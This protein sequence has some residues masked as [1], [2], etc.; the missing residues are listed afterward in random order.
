MVFDVIAAMGTRTV[1]FHDHSLGQFLVTLKVSPKGKGF[2][3]I[4]RQ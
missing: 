4:V 1:V 3:P 2:R